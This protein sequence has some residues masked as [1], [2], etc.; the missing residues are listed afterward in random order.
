MKNQ[1]LRVAIE[2]L[3][4]MASLLALNEQVLTGPERAGIKMPGRNV[5]FSAF[6]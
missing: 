5:E 6:P 3:H 4:F 1:R 2:A